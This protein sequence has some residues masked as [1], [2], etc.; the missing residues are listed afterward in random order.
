[1][2]YRAALLAVL[3]TAAWACDGAPGRP[4]ANSEV[5][6]PNKVVDFA[7][8]YANNCAGCHGP[9]GTGG[10]AIALADPVYLA[11]ADAATIRR[12]TT[13]G[14]PGT[15]MPAFAQSAGG[16]LT[17]EQIDV[18]GNGMR[19]RWA[20]PSILGDTQAPPYAAQA[21][22]DP[23]RGANVYAVYCSSCHGVAGR[24]GQ[25]ASSIVDGAYLAQVSD[26]WLRTMVIVGRPEMGAPDW[27]GDVPGKPLSPDEV[28][29]VVAWLAAQR[30]RHSRPNPGSQRANDS[31]NPHRLVASAGLAQGELQ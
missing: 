20:K 19:E 7:V 21:P 1:M 27:R 26:Q 11:I 6:A 8:L 14:V 28:S 4:A 5:I 31:L 22:G 29:D 23:A 2:D 12:I 17:A 30:P 10:A 15:A 24:G 16:F 18:I 3:A 9:D 25:R 13:D